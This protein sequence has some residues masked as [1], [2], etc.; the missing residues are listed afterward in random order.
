[1]QQRMAHAV[2]IEHRAERL[3]GPRLMRQGA[4]ARAVGIGKPV[5]IDDM[6]MAID[7]V[8]GL[9]AVLAIAF[10]V[11]ESKRCRALGSRATDAVPPARRPVSR[12]TRA[13]ISCPVFPIVSISSVSAPSGSTART[14]VAICW[15]RGPRAAGGVS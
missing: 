6:R 11:V 10:V 3:A 7:D 12:P 4:V 5:R 9:H 15:T 1:N 2:G 8:R 13:T 14:R